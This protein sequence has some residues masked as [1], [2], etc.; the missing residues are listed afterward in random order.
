MFFSVKKRKDEDFPYFH[1]Q[2]NLNLA[3][4]KFLRFYTLNRLGKQA[5]TRMF[6][7]IE[8]FLIR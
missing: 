3:R 6:E 1:L 4:V 7:I 5:F 8:I 2:A